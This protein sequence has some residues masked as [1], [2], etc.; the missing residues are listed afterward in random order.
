VEVKPRQKSTHPE[1][2]VASPVEVKAPQK[3]NHPE[4]TVSNVQGASATS[5][6]TGEGEASSSASPSRSKQP[7]SQLRLSIGKEAGVTAGQLRQVI[8]GET[9]LPESSLGK[10]DLQAKYTTIE[11]FSDQAS[12]AAKKMKRVTIV[13][14]RVKAKLV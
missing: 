3:S 14:K 2:T 8:L 9:A 6:T 10:V 1:K 12:V 11:I 13:G 5:Q 7:R 4:E